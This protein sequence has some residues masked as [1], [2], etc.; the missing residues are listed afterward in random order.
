M[1]TAAPGRAST[2]TTA[3]ALRE[4]LGQEYE[5]ARDQFREL[6]ER[7]VRGSRVAA[8][9]AHSNLDDAVAGAEQ[10]GCGALGMGSS[11]PAP[12]PATRL[13]CRAVP[14]GCCHAAPRPRVRQ[15]L[16]WR[17]IMYAAART[18][19]TSMYAAALKP[20]PGTYTASQGCVG[21]RGCGV[22]HRAQASLQRPPCVETAGRR[23]CDASLR[24]G[25]HSRCCR[26]V[27]ALRRSTR[28]W[29]GRM[30]HSRWS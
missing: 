12:D 14:A 28:R 29:R 25:T 5:V 20:L 21:R 19:C 22:Q 23:C 10:C 11:Q 1:V 26:S 6:D 13:V 3:P 24:R 9:R 8:A 7:H 16:N 27:T 17:D 4:K 30:P 18:S 15:H 2:V